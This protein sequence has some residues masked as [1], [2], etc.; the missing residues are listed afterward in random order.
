MKK[1]LSIFLFTL[2]LISCKKETTTHTPDHFT[3]TTVD[4]ISN[5]EVEITV[6]D[7]VQLKIPQTLLTLIQNEFEGKKIEILHVAF[8]K[9]DNDSLEDAVAIIQDQTNEKP[10]ESI[11]V[12]KKNSTNYTLMAHNRSIITEEYFFTNAH[13]NSSKEIKIEQQQLKIDLYCYGPCGNTFLDFKVNNDDLVLDH[14]S[15]YDAGAGAQ[16]EREYLVDT[17]LVKIKITNTMTEEMDVTE[18]E[19]PFTYSKG[20]RFIDLN[21]KDLFKELGSLESKIIL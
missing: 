19:F 13:T 3:E 4:T 8:G 12:F 11:L 16:I 15:T 14:F 2:L 18:E 20:I 1:L 5:Q 10:S 7:T 6:R 21:T 9:L 17:N